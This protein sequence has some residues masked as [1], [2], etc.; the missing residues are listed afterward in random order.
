MANGE[1]VTS[2]LPF[3]FRFQQSYA[4]PNGKT[5]NGFEN[6]F[7]TCTVSTQKVVHR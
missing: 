1:T 6:G 4:K 5:V 2:V 7:L 3:L